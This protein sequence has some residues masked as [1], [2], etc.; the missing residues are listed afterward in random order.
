MSNRSWTFPLVLAA[1]VTLPGCT[2]SATRVADVPGAAVDGHAHAHAMA[3]APRAVLTEGPTV[4][5][6]TEYTMDNGLRVLLF[7]DPSSPTATVNITYLVGSRHEGYG[8]TGMAHLLEHLLFKGTPN[9]PNIPQELTE[10]GASP[11]GTTWFDRTN[12]FETFAATEENLEWA[13]GLEADRMVNSFV[14]EEDLESEMTVVRNEFESGENS[15]FRVLLQRLMSSMYMW[16]NYGNS[17]IGARADIENV[18]IE[19]LQAFY[20][21]YYQPDNAILVV[22]GRFEPSRVKEIVEEKF[23]VIP[24]P[25]RTGEYRIWPTY[26]VDPVQ[27]GERSVTLRRAGDVQVAGVGYHV[28]PGPHED[29]AALQVLSHVLTNAPTGRLHRALVE[30]GKASSVSGVAFQLRDPSPFMIFAQVREGDSL[31]DAEATMLG[32]IDDLPATP[33]TEAEVDRA[34]AALLR[35]IELAFNNSQMTALQLSEWASMGDWRL[36]FIHRDRL[37]RVTVG[38]VNDVVARYFVPSNRTLAR[39]IPTHAPR[40]ASIPARP[41]VD[42]LVAGYQGRAALAVGEAFDPAPMN[43]DARTQRFTLSNGVEVALLPKTTRGEAV[44]ASITVRFGTLDM[45]MGQ[46]AVGS[47]AGAMLMRGTTERSRSE[48]QDGFDALNTQASISGTANRAFAQLTTTRGNLVPALELAAEVLRRPSFDRSEFEQLKRQRITGIES[49]RS[50]PQPRAFR[51]ISRHGQP[52]PAGHPNY[53]PTFEEELAAAEAVTVE[54]V[55]AYYERMYAPASGTIVVVGDFDPAE[56]RAVLEREIATWERKV[57]FERIATPFHQPP[58]TDIV[59]ETP[60]K[61][62]AVFLAQQSLNISDTHPD[63]PA[64]V[65]GNFML[66]GGFLNSRLATRI[67]QE[68]GLSYGVG[69]S[70]SADALDEN[71]MF[72]A[73]AI[74]APEN[75]E[76]LKAAFSDEMRKLFTD[77]FTAG[78]FE[79]ARTGWLQQRTVQRSNDQYLR[80]LLNNHI[81]YGRSMEFESMFEDRVRALTVDDVNR[82]MRQHLD[83]DLL[84]TVKAG[85]FAG[86]VAG[87][88]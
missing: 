29:W 10:R 20:R 59:I 35:Q 14:A 64:L 68:E 46:S 33:V 88:P 31:E 87:S 32:V 73:F 7:P 85:D 9:H 1:L 12:Y 65:L 63:Y 41:D 74:Y 18:P 47:M 66:G 45:I 80:T 25:D 4:E 82:A 75:R 36:M 37:E 55:A 5:G 58:P 67:R 52:W 51:A 16:H 8:E 72:Q 60:D 40:R 61:A 3:H 56:V 38:A 49:Q 42:A 76:K 21:K 19:R 28:A 30:A 48:I 50:E 78:E 70:L 15:P 69:S 43:I 53:T 62:N 57:P 77:G 71:G 86:Q 11:N 83:M 34:R 81:F 6:I 84:V 54:E 44:Q 22:A 26:T 24:R 17:T 27:D 13:L 79:A 39:F 2:A 23:G